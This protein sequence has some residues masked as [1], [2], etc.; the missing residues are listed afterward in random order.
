MTVQSASNEMLKKELGIALGDILSLRAFCTSNQSSVDEERQKRKRRLFE[1][2]FGNKNPSES[3]K[4]G[5]NVSCSKQAREVKDVKLHLGWQHFDED[6]ERYKQIRLGKGGGMRELKLPLSSN[7]K[8]I[9]DM[10]AK[11]FFVN[12][13]STMGSLDKME[14]QL[15]NFQGD[16]IKEEE[17]EG[18]TLSEYREAYNLPRLKIYLLSKQIK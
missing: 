9:L 17:R 11:T 14:I 5:S 16:F 4:G 2:L 13:E 3:S 12:G 15:G 8:D 1:R 6:S 18:F 10:A 7:Y